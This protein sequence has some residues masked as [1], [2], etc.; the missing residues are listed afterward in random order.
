MA[1]RTPPLFFVY[2]CVGFEAEVVTPVVAP[3]CCVGCCFV[4]A[5]LADTVVA[6]GFHAVVLF[7]LFAIGF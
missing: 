1:K 7:W 4:A 3:C 5:A 2:A 6:T